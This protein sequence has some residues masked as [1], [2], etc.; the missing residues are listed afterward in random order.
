VAKHGSLIGQSL[1]IST[2]AN[3][4]KRSSSNKVQLVR[5]DEQAL[6]NSFPDNIIDP[7]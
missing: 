6:S 1:T 3:M 2:I 7:C 5:Q 4:F